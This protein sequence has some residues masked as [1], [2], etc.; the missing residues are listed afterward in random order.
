MRQPDP[1]HKE[2]KRSHLKLAA[3]H[4][5]TLMTLEVPSRV[6][7]SGRV[8]YAHEHALAQLGTLDDA[9]LR[10]RRRDTKPG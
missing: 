5:A 4:C 1:V 7:C 8:G 3:C 2:L 9:R 6:R 10:S